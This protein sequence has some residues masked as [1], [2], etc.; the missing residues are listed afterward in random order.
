MAKKIKDEVEEKIKPKKKKMTANQKRKLV[1][2]IVGWIMALVMILG[3]LIS[4]FGM[5]IYY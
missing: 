5:L 1:M 2:K 4:I 3:S